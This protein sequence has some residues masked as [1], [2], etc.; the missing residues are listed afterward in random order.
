MK[1]L[2]LD[3]DVVVAAMRSPRGASAAI[4][5]EADAGTVTLLASLPLALEYEA[6]CSR[7]EH[8]RAAELTRDEVQV[9][10]GAVLALVEPVEIYFLWRPQL[11]DPADEMVLEAAINGQAEAIV[12]FN[13]RD[14]GAAAEQFGITVLSPAVALRRIRS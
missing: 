3:T 10:I 5:L 9:F 14:Y 8:R 1:R 4:L 13:R 2:V 11:R 6:V 7:P 12:T